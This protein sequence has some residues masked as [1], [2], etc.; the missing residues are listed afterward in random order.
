[1]DALSVVARD[2]KIRCIYG[3]VGEDK[4]HCLTALDPYKLP[5]AVWVDATSIWPPVG[6]SEAQIVY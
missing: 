5:D 4:K 6:S 3:L 2:H 1:M